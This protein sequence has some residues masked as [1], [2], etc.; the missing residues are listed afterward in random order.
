[1]YVT[2]PLS[3][4]KRYPSALS[5]PPPE[6]P[7]AGILVIQDEAA[8]PKYFFG[9]FKSHEIKDLALP[10]NKD[11]KLRYSTGAN[12]IRHNRKTCTNRHVEHFYAAFIPVLDQPLSSNWSWKLT[13]AHLRKTWKPAISAHLLLLWNQPLHPRN[14]YQQFEILQRGNETGRF[15][16]K[17]IAPDGFPPSSQEEK[18]ESAELGKGNSN[19]VVVDVSIEREEVA[20]GGRKDG[21]VHVERDGFNGLMWSKGDGIS[22]GLSLVILERMEWEEKRFGW[23]GGKEKEVRVKKVEEFGEWKKFGCYVLVER[24]VLK[25]MD[26]SLVLTYDFRHTN[27]IRSRWE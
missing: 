20:I 22:V 5:L 12:N 10:Q 21:G 19:A 3:M 26:G 7:N 9:L 16:A 1:M 24:F 4:Y 17:S 11:I 25:R 23:V 2:R 6:G 15:V 18:N 14:I 13:L 27:Q 8:E